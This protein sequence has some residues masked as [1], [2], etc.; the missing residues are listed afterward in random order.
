MKIPII[1][2][3]FRYFLVFYGYAGKKLG[4]L[5]F[6]V[7]LGGL[8]DSFGL[9]MLLPLLNVGKPDAS[10]DSYT[11]FI[12]QVLLSMGLPVSLY[13]ILMFMIAA[14]SLKGAFIFIQNVVYAS[15]TTNLAKELR[16]NMVRNYADM[17]Y[18]YYI[19]TN[20]GYLNNIV[21]KEIDRAVGGFN[22]YVTVLVNIVYIVLYLCVAFAF[23]WMIT[24]M[25]VVLCPGLFIL[26]RRFSLTIRKLSLGVS[27]MNASIQ[28]ILIQV[29]YNFKYLKATT[30][31]AQLGRKLGKQI[32][33]LRNLTFRIEIINAAP[34]ALLEPLTVLLLS[35]VI[36]AQV[37]L[38]GNNIAG[39]IVLLVFF[40]KTFSRV[41][42]F[43][44]VW[45]HFCAFVGGV[46]VVEKASCELEANKE[47]C[48]GQKLD[49]FKHKIVLRNVNFSYGNR[50]VLFDIN[51]MIPKNKS[52][53]IVGESGAGKT[54]LF[55]IFTGLITPQSG[56]VYIDGID[57]GELEF[58]SLRRMIGYVTQ[59]PVVFNDTIANNISLWEDDSSDD[60]VRKRIEGA[61][62]LAHCIEFIE[63]TENKYESI[64]GDKGMKLSGGQRQRIAIAREIFKKPEIMIFDEATSSLDTES[65]QYIQQ[66]INRMKGNRTI[67]II[68][69]RLSTIRNCDYIYVLSN[70]R[71]VEEGKFDGL[72]EKDDSLFRQMC[73][74]QQM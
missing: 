45:Q 68:A 31:F 28:A 42:G 52:I 1:N 2:N 3:L 61:A 30:S 6:L 74:S 37:V 40:Y 51:L 62:R 49:G 65:E 29:I 8:C 9:S 46:E 70:G 25:V 20:I 13:T 10:L 59:E 22:K 14:F 7:F 43:Q 11:R 4:F 17:K 38:L 35:G 41:F 66:S 39:S 57:Y 15:I 33:K 44:Q 53:G 16:L 24:L 27:E 71:I 60:N 21:T 56:N 55:D 12:H 73:L 72:Y 48:T 19:D 54:T 47:P 36:I 23:N 34:Q 18:Q 26:F 63:K 50:Q 69:H 64:L 5:C 58:S 32:T 67:V